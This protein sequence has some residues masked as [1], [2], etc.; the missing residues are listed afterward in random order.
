MIRSNPILLA[1]VIGLLLFLPGS[2]GTKDSMKMEEK[3]M[4]MNVQQLK[5]WENENMD[6]LN[7]ER[8]MDDYKLDMV[9]LPSNSDGENNFSF[10][11]R[12][13]SK[14]GKNIYESARQAYSDEDSKMMYWLSGVRSRLYLLSDK[15]TVMAGAVLYE[16]TGKLRNELVLNIGFTG[17]FSHSAKYSV[18][19]DDDYLG[20]GKIEFDVT[21]LINNAPKLKL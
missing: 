1:S 7:R 3:P 4:A 19:Y 18:V 15:D 20:L 9:Y 13:R 17:N 5:N 8:T 12:I 10:V 14:E 16:N 2:C 21:E 6:K 11:M